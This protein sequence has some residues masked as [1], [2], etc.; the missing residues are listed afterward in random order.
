VEVEVDHVGPAETRVA[1]EHEDGVSADDNRKL[2]AGETREGGRPESR[3]VHHDVRRDLL[4]RSRC[5]A[6]DPAA[7]K[8]DR[9]HFLSL[10]DQHAAPAR[11]FGIAGG[12]GGG[13]A[14]AGAGLVEHGAEPRGIYSGLDLRDS[15]RGEHLSPHAEAA[16]ERECLLEGRAHGGADADQDAAGDEAGGAGDG[17]AEALEDGERAQHHLGRLRRGVELADNA[18]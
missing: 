12:D 9:R 11:G 15:V 5:Y 6:G 17:L 4:A 7:R 14:I 18:D 2:D 3:R 1:L 13:I 10:V 8:P 16:L